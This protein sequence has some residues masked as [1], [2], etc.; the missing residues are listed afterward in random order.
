MHGAARG[1]QQTRT[2]W[3]ESLTAN[4]EWYL[5][6]SHRAG[7]KRTAARTNYPSL[8][9]TQETVRS[10]EMLSAAN[11]CRREGDLDFQCKPTRLQ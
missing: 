8:C 6:K 7:A 3:D 10:W 1:N 5:Y 2:A 11:R 9:Q 4:G